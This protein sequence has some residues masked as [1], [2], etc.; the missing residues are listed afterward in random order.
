MVALRQK[1]FLPKRCRNVT[2]LA[3]LHNHSDFESL[4]QIV[5]K[6]K[7]IDPSLIEKDYW[8]MHCLYGLQQAGF[9]FKLKGG[10]SLSKAYGII[11]RFSEDIDIEITPPD[12]KDVQIGRNKNKKKHR[13]SRKDFY[14]WLA[15]EIKIEGITDVER[16][17]EFDDVPNY[18]SAGIRLKYINRTAKI[19][20][21]KHGILLE[22]GFDNTSPNE[23]ITISSWAFDYAN[24]KVDIIDNRAA[25]VCCYHPG[26]TFFEKLQAISTKYRKYLDGAELPPNFMRHYYD[27]YCLLENGKVQSFLGTD[28]YY[29]H[30]DRRFPSEDEKNIKEN[31]AFTLKKG[32]V[33]EQLTEAYNKSNSLYY[34][35]QPPF[36]EILARI[37][38]NIDRM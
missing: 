12:H 30:K 14:D 32:T 1:A 18:R 24:S 35:G 34:L 29:K 17:P 6:E 33:K 31:Q 38:E 22:T 8:I 3:Y 28:D 19:V 11:H 36:D 26:Y 9:S 27:I 20:G 16:D 5:A 21:L 23:P 10:T 15:T 13:E 2:K 37:Q 7:K 4:L 25:N